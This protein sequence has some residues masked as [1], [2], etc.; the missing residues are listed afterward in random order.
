MGFI[1]GSFTG[2]DTDGLPPD[3]Y[4]R[5]DEKNCVAGRA[6]Y[7]S[8]LRDRFRSRRPSSAGEGCIG[9]GG[10]PRKLLRASISASRRP[11]CEKRIAKKPAKISNKR[12]G[13]CCAMLHS[14]YHGLASRRAGAGAPEPSSAASGGRAGASAVAPSRSNAH[15]SGNAVL[16]T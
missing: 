11:R 2:L 1:D 9:V 5:S 4:H 13:P 15:L 6:D 7:C 3:V 16:N 14:S 12:S 8:A 10:P